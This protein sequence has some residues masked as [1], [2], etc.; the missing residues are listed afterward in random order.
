MNEKHISTH[1]GGMGGKNFVSRC[2]KADGIKRGIPQM[3]NVERKKRER[4]KGERESEREGERDY[5][6]RGIHE[7]RHTRIPRGGEG[8]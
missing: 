1:G 4:E 3:G 8:F 6:L 5:I 7:V 2:V